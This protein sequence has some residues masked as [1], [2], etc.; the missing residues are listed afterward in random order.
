MLTTFFCCCFFS[1]PASVEI[2]LAG[3]G[4]RPVSQEGFGGSR[5]CD[6]ADGRHIM[7]EVT[8]LALCVCGCV[9]MC[10]YARDSVFPPLE[11][12]LFSPVVCFS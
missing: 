3:Q 2:S 12:L 7:K 1:L 5:R 4:F 10:A 9:C 8:H 6:D 11:L